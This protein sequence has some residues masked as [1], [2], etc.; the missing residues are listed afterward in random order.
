MA[1]QGNI[2]DPDVARGRGPQYMRSE[3]E[4]YAKLINKIGLK[5]E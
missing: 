5:P 2:I 1:S 4:R 3:Q